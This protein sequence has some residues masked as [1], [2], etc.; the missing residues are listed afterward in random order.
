VACD[1][2]VV[3]Q[4]VNKQTFFGMIEPPHLHS[5]ERQ[6]YDIMDLELLGKLAIELSVHSHPAVKRSFEKL[7]ESVGTKR[8]CEDYC[9][10]QKFLMKL[11][12]QVQLTSEFSYF[13]MDNPNPPQPPAAQTTPGSFSQTTFHYGK[14]NFSTPL[15]SNSPRGLRR[16]RSASGSSIPS[17]SFS[18]RFTP[19]SPSLQ[20]ESAPTSPVKN[21]ARKMG[22]VYTSKNHPNVTVTVRKQEDDQKNE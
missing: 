10:L 1:F 6:E 8:F 17:P 12:Q 4:G 5:E 7:V 18:N 3:T 22:I 21:E 9:A 2:V 20:Q 16:W 15:H 14:Q 19:Y 11:H 13:H